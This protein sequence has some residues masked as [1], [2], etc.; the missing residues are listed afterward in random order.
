MGFT[1]GRICSTTYQGTAFGNSDFDEAQQKTLSDKLIVSKI[2]Y[3]ISKR[4]NRQCGHSF[5]QPTP[6]EAKSHLPICEL[7][8]YLST[9]FKYPMSK[10][11]TFRLSSEDAPLRLSLWFFLLCCALP[12]SGVWTTASGMGWPTYLQGTDIRPYYTGGALVLGGDGARL[13]DLDAQWRAQQNAFPGLQNRADLLP[14]L[15][16]PFVAAP[17]AILAMFSVRTAFLIWLACNWIFLALLTQRFAQVLA[18]SGRRAQIFVVVACITC[19]PVFVTLLQGQWA[20]VLALSS[21]FAWQNLRENRGF[22]GGLWISLWLFKPQLLLLLLAVLLWKKQRRAL[23]G[24]AAGSAVLGSVSLALIGFKGLESYGQLL[25]TA[26]GWSNQFGVRPEAMYTWRGFLHNFSDQTNFW[27]WLGV[28]PM[29]GV[30][31]WS[32]RDAWPV[33]SSEDKSSEVESSEVESREIEASKKPATSSTRSARDT[34]LARFDAC[35]AMTIFASLF[36]SPYLYYHDLTLLLVP[37]FLLASAAQNSAALASPRFKKVMLA[38]PVFGFV[39]FWVE[40]FFVGH[41][42]GT[43]APNVFFMALCVAILALFV[44]NQGHLQGRVLRKF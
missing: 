21:F 2:E 42:L 5:I 9:H 30:L 1:V 12:V 35:W 16:P 34:E 32:W 10:F 13:Y 18:P 27:W 23:A 41:T 20:L 36:C 39:L 28:L 25:K 40:F 29:L 31:A 8:N 6:S 17:M 37:V 7:E 44:R 33:E 15:A 3:Q 38:L 19:A 26:S 43:V 14:F 4:S 11:L 22:R 24:F